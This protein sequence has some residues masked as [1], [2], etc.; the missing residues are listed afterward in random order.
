M[1][2]VSFHKNLVNSHSPK[3]DQDY[4][5]A[6]ATFL[7]GTWSHGCPSSAASCRNFNHGTG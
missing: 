2:E 5:Q 3:F 7:G 6:G 4:L 1:L